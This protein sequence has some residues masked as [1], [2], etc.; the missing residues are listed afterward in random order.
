MKKT[1]GFF[2]ISI[3]IIFVAIGCYLYFEKAS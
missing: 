1:D 3:A 2:G